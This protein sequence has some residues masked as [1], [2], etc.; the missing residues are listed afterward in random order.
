MAVTRSPWPAP[1]PAEDVNNHFFIKHGLPD[2]CHGV[3]KGRHPLEVFRRAHVELLRHGELGAD[4][5]GVPTMLGREYCV[6]RR[7]HFG[8]GACARELRQHI[9]N[10]G[11]QEA[12]QN[13]LILDDPIDVGRVF[14]F[15]GGGASPFSH[16]GWRH[17][18]GA[19]EID[20]F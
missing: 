11:G 2:V 18:S 13:R 17:G 8:R 7:P 6:E 16:R 1:R 4:L 10:H 5:D 9:L 14:H 12:T 3:S 19:V 20:R 15:P